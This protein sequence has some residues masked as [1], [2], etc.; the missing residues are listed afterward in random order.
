M[1]LGVPSAPAAAPAP[2]PQLP[3]PP[4]NRAPD[5]PIVDPNVQKRR[6][7][8]SAQRTGTSVFRNDLSIPSSGAVGTGINIPT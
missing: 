8:T 6:D 7:L 2:A 3:P 1:C 5:S 4:P